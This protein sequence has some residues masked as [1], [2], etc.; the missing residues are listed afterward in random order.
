MCPDLFTE[1]CQNIKER[2]N[3]KQVLIKLEN[4]STPHPHPSSPLLK[5]K[6]RHLGKA[7]QWGVTML[8]HSPTADIRQVIK[9]S[10][11]RRPGTPQALTGP[12]ASREVGS[13][14]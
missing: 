5:S 10:D 12:L 9:R 6:Y 13:T 8:R 11:S 2:R 3:P 14:K 7:E 4:N 1:I